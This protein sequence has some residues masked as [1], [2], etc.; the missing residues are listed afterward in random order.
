MNTVTEISGAAAI[1]LLCFRVGGEDYAIDISKTREIRGWTTPSPMPDAPEF[2]IG[3]INLRGVVLPLLDLAAR[4]DL[5]TPE[6]NERSVV[7]VAEVNELKTGLLVDAVSDIIH[8]SADEMQPPPEA[9]TSSDRSYVQA[10]TFI[11]ERMVRV[12]DLETVMLS[13]PDA[14]QEV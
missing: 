11:G 8:P 1:E 10:L 12:L 13:V 2:V 14:A 4:L 9:A 5:P 6:T 3:V 7:I